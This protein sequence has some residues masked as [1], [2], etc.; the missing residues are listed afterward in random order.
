MMDQSLSRH[1]RKIS[2]VCLAIL[3]GCGDDGG[4]GMP[5][6]AGGTAGAAGTTTDTVG[7]SS[8]TAGTTSGT[9]GTSNTSQ[10]GGVGGTGG[11]G[12]TGGVG[13][14]G[15]T[16]EECT[17]CPKGCFSL[18][19]DPN[20]C[21][22]CGYACSTSIPGAMAVCTMGECGQ[23]C[24]NPNE[25]IC[26]NA[27]VD[28]D[29]NLDHCGKCGFDCWTPTGGTVACVD[30]WCEKTCPSGRT[31]CGNECVDL[32]KDDEN[33]GSCDNRC[34]ALTPP[35][36][37]LPYSCVGGTCV[38]DCPSGLTICDSQCVNLL[39]DNANC[40][41]CGHSCG[42]YACE[43]GSCSNYYCEW[44]ACNVADSW[45]SGTVR[46]CCDEDEI[47]DFYWL[48]DINGVPK[49]HYYCGPKG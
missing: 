42:N 39:E 46:E 4:D 12:A 19:S 32:T 33:C 9:G 38:T 30:G 47:C 7:N 29:S 17:V 2:L 13:G 5:T 16:P 10:E 14:T 21:G 25:T 11:V 24:K 43:Q 1:A 20:N 40:G 41:S 8:G 6:G 45:S 31:L 37:G 28:L 18:D 15:G 36:G 34:S 27:C 3:V 26:D 49:K 44:D 22:S 48:N 35:A 23:T